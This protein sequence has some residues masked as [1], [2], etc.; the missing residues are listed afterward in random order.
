LVNL[1]YKPTERKI[2]HD[3]SIRCW[4]I[5][6]QNWTPLQ[7]NSLEEIRDKVCQPNIIKSI[8]RKSIVYISRFLTQNCSCLKEIQG[9]KM[10]KRLK[11][12]SSRDCPTLESIPCMDTKPWH[13]CWCQD[14]LGDRLAWMS[15]ERF[16][17]YLT[18]TDVDTQR[19]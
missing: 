1:P 4:K 15:S 3:P 14:L 16:C 6:W 11:E 19:Y 7:V 12:K 8:S 5:L 18:K 13:Y 10:E 2:S 9:Q 17:Q